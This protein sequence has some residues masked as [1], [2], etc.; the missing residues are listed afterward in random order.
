VVTFYEGIS[1]GR[2]SEDVR[3]SGKDV[4][5]TR[6]YRNCRD[7]PARPRR[8]VGVLSYRDVEPMP[9]DTPPPQSRNR[10]Q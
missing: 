9:Y 3:I 1:S 8:P 6:G 4:F 10:K 5:V 2:Y 7:I